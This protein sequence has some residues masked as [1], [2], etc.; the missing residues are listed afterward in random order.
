MH[1]WPR[2]RV[3]AVDRPRASYGAVTRAQ[4]RQPRMSRREKSWRLL[5]ANGAGKST[6][7]RTDFRP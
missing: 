2:R 3:L 1:S 5:G 7:L 6:T 4:G